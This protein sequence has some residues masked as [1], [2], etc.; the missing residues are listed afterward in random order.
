[1]PLYDDAKYIGKI[2]G[3]PVRNI[4]YVLSGGCFAEQMVDRL[5]EV[6]HMRHTGLPGQASRHAQ[7]TFFIYLADNPGK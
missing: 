6:R 1:M 3:F 5:R 7:N 4:K 2:V